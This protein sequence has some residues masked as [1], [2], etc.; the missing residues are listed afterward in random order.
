M[1]TLNTKICSKCGQEKPQDQF[2]PGRNQCRQCRN[3]RRKELRQKHPEKHREE[4]TKRQEEQKKWLYSLKT[5]C[6]IC[7][8]TEPVCLDF[9]HKDPNEKDFTISKHVSRS[10]ENLLM[11]INKCVCL[12]ANCHRKV[13]AGIINLQDYLDKS[14]LDSPQESVTE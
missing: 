2:E 13:H 6:L 9:H 12:C 11:E 14:S 3:A 5:Q 4:A 7:G 1:S 10:K 8:E